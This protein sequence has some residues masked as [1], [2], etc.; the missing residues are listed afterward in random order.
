MLRAPLLHALNVNLVRWCLQRKVRENL[1]DVLETS[2][3]S[4]QQAAMALVLGG[5]YKNVLFMY[6]FRLMKAVSRKLNKITKNV[7]IVSAEN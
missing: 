3:P 4:P 1:Q 7:F 2:F 5:N 6:S